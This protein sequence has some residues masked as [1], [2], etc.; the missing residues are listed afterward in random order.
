M[1]FLELFSLMTVRCFFIFACQWFLVH[2]F[3]LFLFAFLKIVL[4]RVI[5]LSTDPSKNVV[6][7]YEAR[8]FFNPPLL[9]FR[10]FPQQKAIIYHR[11]IGYLLFFC[12]LLIVV[13]QFPLGTHL[14]NT[15]I[16]KNF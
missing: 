7:W 14:F 3:S 13:N 11:K 1:Y 9:K 10:S 6:F 12:A 2:K 8:L 15:L 16:L 4:N 5:R